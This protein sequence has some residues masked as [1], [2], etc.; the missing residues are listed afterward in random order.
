MAET[1]AREAAFQDKYGGELNAPRDTGENLGPDME[2][3]ID[4]YD[5]K[6]VHELLPDLND[7][8]LKE[9]RIMRTGA[10]LDEGA[11]YFDLAHPERGEFRGM[12]NMAV[13]EGCYLVP[14]SDT[15]Y[16]L[17]NWITKQREPVDKINRFADAA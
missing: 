9:L 17:W 4:A 12:N 15:G 5:V 16:D 7:A 13:E 8:A 10:R 14:K 1:N 6:A 2:E 3:T 11:V